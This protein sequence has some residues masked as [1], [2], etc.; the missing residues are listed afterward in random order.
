[1]KE[2]PTLSAIHQTRFWSHVDRTGDCWLWKGALGGTAYGAYA[3]DGTHY[4][5]HRIAVVLSGR[6]LEDGQVVLHSCDNRLCVNPNHL[7][8]GT[9]RDNVRDAV[10][11]GR[12]NCQSDRAE[13]E[14]RRMQDDA[15]EY[16]DYLHANLCGLGK[17][18]NVGP[19]PFDFK[20]WRKARYGVKEV[21]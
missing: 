14:W 15:V 4:A 9:Q 17:A 11:K 10:A 13:R 2:I 1:M 12:A 20:T 5:A 6:T 7:T 8:V 19:M 3:I 18:V 21:A 16:L